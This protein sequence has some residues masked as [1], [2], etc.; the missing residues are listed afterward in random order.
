MSSPRTRGSAQCFLCG[1]C[2]PAAKV[3]GWRCDCSHFTEQITEDWGDETTPRPAALTEFQHWLLFSPG[4]H[5]HSLPALLS[6]PAS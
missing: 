3:Y 4:A 1:F 6:S 5:L 2:V